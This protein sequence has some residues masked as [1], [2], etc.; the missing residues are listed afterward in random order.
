MDIAQKLEYR[1]TPSHDR[2]NVGRTR[3]TAGRVLGHKTSF[4][5]ACG[6]GTTVAKV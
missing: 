2:R 6:Q 4:V 3:L 5:D 1:G